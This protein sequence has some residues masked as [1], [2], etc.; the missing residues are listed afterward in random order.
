MVGNIDLAPTILEIAQ[1]D[2]P[3]GV[4]DGESLLPYLRSNRPR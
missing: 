4:L 1:A 2:G 3:V